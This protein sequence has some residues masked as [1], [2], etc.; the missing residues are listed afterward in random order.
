[1]PTRSKD[2]PQPDEAS[3]YADPE[4]VFR[5]RMKELRHRHDITQQDL[6]DRLVA[7]GATRFTNRDAIGRIERGPTPTRTADIS[8]ADAC[9]IAMAL[10]VS[11]IHM[12]LPTWHADRI[13]ITPDVVV[14]A[15]SAR[16]WVRGDYPLPG[17]HARKFFTEIAI[18]YGDRLLEQVAVHRAR[19]AEIELTLTLPALPEGLDDLPLGERAEALKAHE[20]AVGKAVAR[21]NAELI[22]LGGVPAAKSY[23]GEAADDFKKTKP[24]TKRKR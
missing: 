22:E 15:G 3:T 16:V 14:P 7:L 11:L 17:Q 19:T 4:A 10:D 21:V 18:Q 1:M 2:I 13:A 24:P 5:L 23:L 20:A 6:A 8:L 9:A 12:M